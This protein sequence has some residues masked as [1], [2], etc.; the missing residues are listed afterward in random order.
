MSKPSRG[1]RCQCGHPR[2]RHGANA[3][4]CLECDC[5]QLVLVR[6]RGERQK[7]AAPQKHW[8]DIREM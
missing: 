8:R 3:G 6:E 2:I 7:V 1:Q 5:T 4:G